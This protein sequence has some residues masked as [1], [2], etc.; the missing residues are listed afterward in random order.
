[1]GGAV[2]PI[3]QVMLSELRTICRFVLR[4]PEALLRGLRLGLALA[5]L[6]L[7]SALVSAAAVTSEYTLKAKFLC[8]FSKYVEWP[9]VF[10][11]DAPLVFGVVGQDPAGMSLLEALRGNSVQGRRVQVAPSIASLEDAK[12]CHVLFFRSGM[13][14]PAREL[15]KALRGSSVLTVGEDNDFLE[16]GGIALLIYEDGH[17]RFDINPAAARSSRLKISSQLLKLARA[18][19]EASRE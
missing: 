11:G 7:Y 3:R 14:K 1:M 16:L 18:L 10:G 8:N 9:L 12:R 5:A 15:L 13:P 17:L 4:A 2:A 19:P 6:L